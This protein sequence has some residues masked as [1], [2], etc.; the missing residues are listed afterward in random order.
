MKHYTRQDFENM[1]KSKLVA[2]YTTRQLKILALQLP[3]VVFAFALPMLMWSP[4]VVPMVAASVNSMGREKLIEACWSSQQELEK[5]RIVFMTESMIIKKINSTL[6]RIAYLQKDSGINLDI[7]LVPSRFHTRDRDGRELLDIGKLKSTTRRELLRILINLKGVLRAERAKLEDVPRNKIL[8]GSSSRPMTVMQNA[9]AR[10]HILKAVPAWDKNARDWYDKWNNEE[11]ARIE[12]GARFIEV[13]QSMA[14]AFKSKIKLVPEDQKNSKI[15]NQWMMYCAP[16]NALNN[17]KSKFV[18]KIGQSEFVA[19]A[20]D[21]L[22]AQL[23]D[24]IYGSRPGQPKSQ[25]M[26]NDFI[27]NFGLPAFEKVTVAFKDVVAGYERETMSPIENYLNDKGLSFDATDCKIHVKDS[28]YS[29]DIDAKF[30]CPLSFE[31]MMDPVFTSV[32]H[33]YDRPNIKAWF[34]TGSSI[35]PT[36]N[37]ICVNQVLTPSMPTRTSILEFLDKVASDAKLASGDQPGHVGSKMK[38]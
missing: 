24:S 3:E 37:V 11:P 26:I 38:L 15:I 35:D 21:V 20:I 14:D 36:S 4:L 8:K 5:A 30:L 1:S 12:L 27:A 33:V 29:A 32:G 19:D 31:L 17:I 23:S 34:D 6:L 2:K 16:N 25:D 7:N 22:L 13:A 28:G 18:S 10:D 9:A